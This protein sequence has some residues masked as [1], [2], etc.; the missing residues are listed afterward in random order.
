MPSSLRSAGPDSETG[1][2]A[3]QSCQV[4]GLAMLNFV[5]NAL[6]NKMTR[7]ARSSKTGSQ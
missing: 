7:M 1:P 5:V 3:S 2:V 4:E 6:G